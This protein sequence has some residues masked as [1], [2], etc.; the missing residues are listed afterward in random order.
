MATK[1]KSTSVLERV[2]NVPLRREYLKAPNWKRTKKAASA[3]R[4]FLARHMKSENIKISTEINE[5]LWEKGIRN[6]PHHIKVTATKDEKG[7]V[8][9]ELFGTKKAE[10]SK[11]KKAA[12]KVPAKKDA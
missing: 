8:K 12:A 4:E 5:V 10:Q 7:A 2:Y 9:V 1:E 3:L 11:E 6:P